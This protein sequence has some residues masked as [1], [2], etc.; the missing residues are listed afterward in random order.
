MSFTPSEVEDIRV[1]FDQ[2]SSFSVSI[3]SAIVC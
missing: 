3:S 1:Q 2:V